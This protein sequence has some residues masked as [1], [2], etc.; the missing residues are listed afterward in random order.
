M[1][2][3]TGVRYRVKRTAKGPVRLAIKGGKV[4]EAIKMKDAPKER[5]SVKKRSVKT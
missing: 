2:L 4:L 5:K 3:G 1:P